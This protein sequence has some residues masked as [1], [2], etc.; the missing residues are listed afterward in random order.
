MKSSF[1]S[2]DEFCPQIPAS[3]SVP[4]EATY[5]RSRSVVAGVGLGVLGGRID[6]CKLKRGLALSRAEILGGLARFELRVSCRASGTGDMYVA[7]KETCRCAKSE[8]S[9]CGGASDS[10]A[11]WSMRRMRKVR[12]CSSAL[13]G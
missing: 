4:S 6:G 2:W 11:G 7:S 9:G 13:Y 3:K 8:R 10:G 12:N 1:A 5:F